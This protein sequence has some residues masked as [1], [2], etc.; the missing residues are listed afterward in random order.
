MFDEIEKAHPDVAQLLLQVLED[1]RLTD[2]LGRTVDFRNTI[3]ILTSNVGAHILQKKQSLGFGAE[4]DAEADYEK[5]KEKV[6]DE[7]KKVF[8]P[9]FLNRIN[10]IVLFRSLSRQDMG[11]IVDIE[12]AKIEK[13]LDE[14]KLKIKLDD[15]A[16][17]FLVEKGW[18]E[19]YGA[20]PLKRALERELEDPMAEELLK[21]KI[22]KDGGLVKVSE[23]DGKLVFSQRKHLSKTSS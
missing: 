21:G 3:I 10:D 7:M 1:G 11:K 13:R 15:S 23:K 14:Q 6:L 12:L 19:K 22:Q 9:E 20:R 18:D 2:S 16:K 4:T 8:R 5:T 17:E